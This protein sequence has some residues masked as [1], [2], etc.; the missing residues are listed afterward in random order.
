MKLIKRPL[1]RYYGGKWKIAPWI[2]SHFP[3]HKVYCEPFGGAASVLLTKQPSKVEIYN[4]LSAEVVNLFRVLRCDESR[5][6]LIQLLHYTPYSRQEWLNCFELTED[7]IELARR[8]IVL[9]SM[10]HNVSKSLQRLSNGFRT[11]TAGDHR[12]P[13]DFKGVTQNLYAVADRFKNV[14]IENQDATKLMNQ[15][16]AKDTLHYLDPP[17]LAKTRSDKTSY[18][19]HELLTIDEHQAFGEAANN[20]TGYAILS[21]YDNELYKEIYEDNGWLKVSTKTV[22]GAATKGKSHREECIWLNPKCAVNQ[23]QLRIQYP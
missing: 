3:A 11:N 12:H 23:K 18:Y 22:T 16:D 6:R 17:Y 13:Y 2:I 8:T 15:H 20:L 9:A 14:I 1:I 5:R 4:D 19:Q 21:G 7:P 10:S